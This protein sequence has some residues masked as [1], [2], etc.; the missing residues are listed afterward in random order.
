MTATARG[1]RALATEVGEL[2]AHRDSRPAGADYGRY[3]DDPHGFIRDVL[4]V[5]LTPQQA[6]LVG[7][8]RDHPLNAVAAGVAMGKDHAAACLAL[9]WTFAR[10]GLVLLSSAT[11]RQVIE[12]GLGE[13]R[14]LWNRAEMPGDFYASGLRIAGDHARTGVLGFVST[15]HDAGKWTGH[16]SAGGVLVILSEAQSC[17]D[18]AFEGAIS[19]AVG[20]SDRVVAVGNPLFASGRFAT[21]ERAPH[22]QFHRW[23]AFDHPNVIEGRAVVPGAVTREAIAR[24][25]A[26]Y[27]EDS[28]IYRARVLGEFPADDPNAQLLLRRQWIAA[29]VER[30]EAGV[31]DDPNGE[32]C[33]G[34]DVARMGAD[35]SCLAVRQGMTMRELIPW[36]LH[37][38]DETAARTIAEL[39]SRGIPTGKH[40]VFG[41]DGRPIAAGLVHVD[42]TGIG[43]GVFDMLRRDGHNVA[44]F[45]A[46]ARAG[47]PDRFTNRRAEAAWT[48]RRLLERDMIALPP[49]DDLTQELV[50]LRWQV[51]GAGR[52]Q[53]EDKTLL[54]G[55]LGRSPDHAD[56]VM[57]AFSGLQAS[58]R[59]A[60]GQG[61]WTF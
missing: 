13:V 51:D 22:W 53:L 30:W 15:A 26:E 4:M 32:W 25:A 8:V 48:L 41:I 10:G 28:A 55:R 40:R 56:A 52:V 17:P 7:D 37:T 36:Q 6:A 1:I 2:I 21:L 16:H 50:A 61:R 3:R 43:A 45:I 29:A 11:E 18:A 42:S 12:I 34:L 31:L 9:W 60:W 19:C 38:T 27:G 44:E 57:M 47:E 46:A 33:A 58:D 54:R 20:A 24:L 49:S 5:D 35:Q 14:H 59:Q 39:E 23:S